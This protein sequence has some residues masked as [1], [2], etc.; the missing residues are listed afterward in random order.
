MIAGAGMLAYAL[1]V[2]LAGIHPRI[3]VSPL[4]T[5][6]PFV[7]GVAIAGFLVGAFRETRKIRRI[8]GR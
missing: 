6:F 8:L 3:A 2:Y 1:R 5:L 7:F 4:R